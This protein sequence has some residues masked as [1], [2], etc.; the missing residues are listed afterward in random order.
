MT[1]FEKA[2]CCVLHAICER[3]V[4]LGFH[5]GEACA[6][7]KPDAKAVSW[8]ELREIAMA[9]MRPS[10]DRAEPCMDTVREVAQACV[11]RGYL[12]ERGDDGY[13]ITPA[14]VLEFVRLWA[15]RLED[16]KRN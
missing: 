3:Q 6:R 10:P 1:D 8:P 15:E 7:L 11:L 14:G 12:N 5:G 4:D 9:G 16:M 2:S 13:E